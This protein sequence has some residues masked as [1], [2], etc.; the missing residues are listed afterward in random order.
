MLHPLTFAMLL[1][2][3]A[4]MALTPD[5][6][7]P[8]GKLPEWA[9]PTAYGLSFKIDPAQHGYTG[10]VDIDL[11][12]TQAADHLWLHGQ[13]LKVQK[14][15]IQAEGQ[16]VIPGKYSVAAATDGVSQLTFAK[17]LPAGHYRLTLDFSAQYNEQLEGIYKVTFKG[18]PYVMTQMEAISARN[19]FP[20]FD[21]PR[22]KTPFTLRVTAPA[23][24]TIAANTLP[25]K[26]DTSLKGW[27]TVT[28]SPTKPLPTYLVALAVGPWDR[29]TGPDI[30]PTPYRSNTLALGGV[31]PH[32][33][34]P[35]MAHA[36]SETP[37][38]IH[39]LEDYFAFGYPWDKLDL[40]AAP[41]F[42][43][44][45]ME[46]PGLVTFRDFYMLLDEHSPVSYVQR[47]FN[48]NAHELSHQWFGDTVTTK[49]WDDI[50]LN[51]AFATWMQSKVTQHLHPE[52]RA[53]LE[54]INGANVAMEDD[55]LVSVRRIR[56]PIVSNADI[57]TAFDNITYQK[58]AA[59]LNMFERYLGTEK[60]RAGIRSYIK[61]HQFGNAT[62]DDLIASLAEASG[63]GDRFTQ[64]M[65]SFLNQPGV[66]RVETHLSVVNGETH[67]H[68]TQQRYLPVGSTGSSKALWGIPVCIRYGEP[69]APVAQSQVQC[70][71]LDQAEGDVVLKGASDKVWYIPNADAAGYYHFA[72]APDD[73]KRLSAQ[74]AKLPDTEQLAFADAVSASYQHGDSDVTAVIEAARILAASP[75]RQVA[76][77]LIP[78]LRWI[79]RYNVKTDAERQQLAKVAHDLYLPRL[80]LLGYVHRTGESQ[81]DTLLRA[82]LADFLGL[83]IKL[84]EVRQALLTQADLALKAGTDGR[85]N[86]TAVEPELLGTILA[87]AVQERGKDIQQH[88]I[89]ELAQ[90]AEPTQRQALLTG[91]GSATDAD[92]KVHAR[93]LVLD[94]HVKVGELRTL[95]PALRDN[96]GDRDGLW[97]WFLPHSDALIKRI[98]AGSSGRLPNMVGGSGCSQADADRLTAFFEPRLK[99]LVGAERGL[100]QTREVALLCKALADKQDATV[101]LK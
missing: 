21:E 29:A 17:V 57:E 16:P 33:T 63:Q 101:L 64:A 81:D 5:D 91:I 8:H 58:G 6:T 66:P 34:G 1:V 80:Q 76:T 77:A 27:H 95:F 9:V 53:D 18:L 32:G 60:F 69:G 55:S 73:F 19:A 85:L 51:E 23:G 100:A 38:I 39:T 30:A 70:T 87:V 28:F 45:A 20:G 98:G 47:S 37:A 89:A 86:L 78:T 48:V 56:Q 25:V 83:E 14:V 11:D 42:A 94:S 36:L 40:L 92:G 13:E 26:D 96:S 7:V 88:L 15:V 12:L 67:L 93:D 49:W 50:W 75:T 54:L 68:L 62:A 97:Q 59:V 90:N 44:G 10:T 46:N 2:S 4:T 35:K 84:P 31:A 82:S 72:E 22:F 3:S 74:V 52:Y 43:A 41:D 61:A 65:Q 79:N 71:L 24:Q 99:T